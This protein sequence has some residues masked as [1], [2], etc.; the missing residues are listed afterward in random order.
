MPLIVK[1]LNELFNNLSVPPVIANDQD[2]ETEEGRKNFDRMLFTHYNDDNLSPTPSCECGNLKGRYKL[3]EICSRCLTPV[4]ESIITDIDPLVWIRA[5]AGVEY[6]VTPLIWHILTKRIGSRVLSWVNYMC[7]PYYRI[8]TKKPYQLQWMEQKGHR[9]G[10]NYFIENFDEVLKDLVFGDGR[11]K[12]VEKHVA[13]YNFI[14]ENR[15]KVFVKYIPM[16]SK[17]AFVIEESAGRRWADRTMNDAIDA[18]RRVQDIER[19]QGTIPIR[20]IESRVTRIMN[21]FAQFYYDY[22]K[23]NWDGKRMIFRKH[24]FGGRLHFTARGVITSLTDVHSKSELHLPWAM[25]LQLFKLHLA[26]KL[27]KRGYSAA[28]AN[29]LINSNSYHYH[30]LLDELF[31][32]LISE[33]PHMGIPCLFQRNPTLTRASA[34]LLYITKIKTSTT[35]NT[36]SNSVLAIKGNNADYDGDQMNLTLLE[37]NEQVEK[38]RTLDPSFNVMSLNVPYEISGNLKMPAPVIATIANWME[39]DD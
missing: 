6:L 8:T 7:D 10:L 25:S 19:S 31:K 21:T 30:P 13:V 23:K 18:L 24:V 33:S 37:S 14:Q 4:V 29:E 1:D 5:P 15:D 28:A 2:I 17:V 39:S 35:D 22:I 26:N 27:I 3:N 34:Q 11:H 20:K 16:P 32:E 9:R 12:P 38:F 36:I